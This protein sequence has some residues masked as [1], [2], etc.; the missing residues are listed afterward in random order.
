MTPTMRPMTST[1]GRRYPT[2]GL[3]LLAAGLV[4]VGGCG[5]SAT[6]SSTAEGTVTGTVTVRGKRATEGTVTF[7][8]SNAQRKMVPARTAPIGKDGTYTITTLVG[9]NHVEV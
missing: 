1:M 9:G 7:D 5:H 6:T 8:P 2:P 4:A 3:A